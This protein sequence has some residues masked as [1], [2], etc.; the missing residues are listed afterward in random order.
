MKKVLKFAIPL[1]LILGIVGVERFYHYLTDGFDLQRIKSNLYYDSRFDVVHAIEDQKDVKQLFL[2]LIESLVD[3][4]TW[5][6][7]ISTG[8]AGFEMSMMPTP[9]PPDE[10]M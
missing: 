8:A 5:G 6:G 9:E 1:L 4:S 3:V 7:P 2:R 10:P